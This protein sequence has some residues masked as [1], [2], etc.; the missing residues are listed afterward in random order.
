MEILETN[1][2]TIK[3]LAS[4]LAIVSALSLGFN[5]CGGGGGSDTTTTTA[6]TTDITDKTTIEVDTEV[7]TVEADTVETDTVDPIVSLVGDETIY[8]TQGDEYVEQGASATDDVDGTLDV[9][10]AGSVDTNV[11]NTYII[12]YTAEDIAGNMG[13]ATRDVVVSRLIVP[14]N[15]NDTT[16]DLLVLYGE[17]SVALYN[18]DVSTRINHLITITN[19]IHKDSN[20]STIFKLIDSRKHTDFVD[21]DDS[22]KMLVDALNDTSITGLRDDLNADEVIMYKPYSGDGYCGLAWLNTPLSDIYAYGVVSIDCP[23]ET[24]AHELGHN[25]GLSH[26]HIQNSVGIHPYSLG[27]G[28]DGLFSTIMAYFSAFNV[29]ETT[30]VFSSPLLDCSGSPCGIDEGYT[31]E[32]DAVKSIIQTKT[33]I[34]AFR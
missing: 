28:E 18:N 3:S 22:A 9:T 33:T 26:S 5:G 13:T 2:K 23:T 30:M 1:V 20:T 14:A 31:G 7:D 25:F 34:S 29:E 4:S 17:G 6:T 27:H 11:P 32:A 24:T 10:I 19:K 21:T 12:T 15:K 16:V 8:L